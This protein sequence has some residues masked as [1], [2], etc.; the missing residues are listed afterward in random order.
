MGLNTYI[1]KEIA[2]KTSKGI[3][4]DLSDYKILGEGELKTKLIIT[5]KSASETAKEKIKKSGGELIL[6][7]SA[8]SEDS[9]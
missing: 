3:E 1:K 2:K 7:S 8:Q 5:A 6:H 9:E 4:L